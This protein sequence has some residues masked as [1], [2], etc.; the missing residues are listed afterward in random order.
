[1]SEYPSDEL[2]RDLYRLCE[3]VRKDAYAEIV[4][5]M[6][7]ALDGR[8]V[9]MENDETELEERLVLSVQ[10]DLIEGMIKWVEGLG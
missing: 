5:G 6:Y 1:M 10:I 7:L 2:K 9:E 8:R 4:A 3:L